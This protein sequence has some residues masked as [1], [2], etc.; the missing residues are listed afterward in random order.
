MVQEASNNPDAY[1]RSGWQHKRRGRPIESGPAWDYDIGYNWLGRSNATEW[2][3]R[4]SWIAQ[5]NGEPQWACRA[6]A[7]Y[8][9]LRAPGQALDIVWGENLVATTSSQLHE[10]FTRDYLRWPS[11]YILSNEISIVSQYISDRMNFM[12]ATIQNILQSR[13]IAS[14]LNPIT[15][16]ATQCAGVLPRNHLKVTEFK[17]G[18]GEFIE[19]KNIGTTAFDV[20]GYEFRSVPALPTLSIP[21][22]SITFVFPLK[23]STTIIPAGG[24]IVVAANTTG[25]IGQAYTYSGYLT[26]GQGEI[27]LNDWWKFPAVMVDYG[28]NGGWITPST[29]HTFVSSLKNPSGNQNSGSLWVQSA[30]VGGS[31]GA[32]DAASQ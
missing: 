30:N 9:D 12:D 2:K 21:Q 25:P 26:L 17:L 3:V 4:G 15:N 8:F 32:D 29:G 5:M 10:V 13:I 23:Q 31:P 1:D 22:C 16:L 7:R 6:L 18:A 11:A 28:Y 14:P 20:A 19:I 27:V 24:F